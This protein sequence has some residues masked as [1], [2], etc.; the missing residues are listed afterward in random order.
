MN[1]RHM[2]V[3]LTVVE[4]NS[5]SRAAEK[6]Y[7]TQPA[8]TQ[9]IR[10]LEEEFGGELF[11]Y[12]GKS[13]EL[14]PLGKSCVIAFQNILNQYRHL[15]NIASDI[16][17]GTFGSLTVYIPLRRAQVLLPLVLPRFSALY[18]NINVKIVEG[19]TR[20]EYMF[21][22]L[23]DGKIDLCVSLN[24]IVD[25]R[26][27][28]IPVCLETMVYIT[29]LNN[30]LA[31]KFLAEKRQSVR[32]E[33]LF[34][35]KLVLTSQIYWNRQL[36]DQMYSEYNMQPQTILDVQTVELCKS[37][38]ISNYA[39]TIIPE[40]ILKGSSPIDYNTNSLTLPIDNHLAKRHISIGYIK[41]RGLTEYQ[42]TFIEL[43]KEVTVE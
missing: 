36:V 41:D 37:L 39:S 31:Q 25:P 14:S 29:S 2:E 16:S 28:F 3:F 8:V 26:I 34:Q 18:P 43:L 6:L 30:P 33:E 40:I 11:I 20:I 38:A 22:Q 35:E 21:D 13:K 9:V 12:H 23:I 19:K 15:Q 24:R 1:H 5:I 32:I 4:E 10:K 27:D 17:S 7:I 42:K